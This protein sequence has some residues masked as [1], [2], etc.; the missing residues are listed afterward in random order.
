MT[1][2][3]S[4]AR[5]PRPPRRPPSLAC[6]EVPAML[7]LFGIAVAGCLCF[8]AAT[9]V[10]AQE[11][12]WAQ[13]MFEKQSID[14][15]VVA[16]GADCI[17][18][19]KVTNLYQETIYFRNVSTSCGCS[20]AK[21]S[22]NEIPSGQT[23]YV[24]ISMDTK[25][26]MRKK[27]SSALITLAEPSK[28]LIQE[29][30]I[31]LSVYIRTD[32]VFTPGSANFGAVDQGAPAERKLT[33]N[34]AG[35]NDW[36]IKEVKSPQSYITGAAV[37]TGRPGNGLVNYEVVVNLSA[38]APVGTLRELLTIVTNDDANP[39]VPLPVEARIESEFT[40]QPDLLA[41]GAVPVGQSKTVN[42]VVRGRKPFKI[43]KIEATNPGEAFKVRLPEVERQVHVL[44]FT[45]TAP[46][47]AG[48]ID[49]VFTLLIEGRKEPLTIRAK[50][51]VTSAT[52][53]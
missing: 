7:R 28:G 52:G 43:E 10:S 29:V 44:P 12:N 14:F 26:F 35:R 48:E 4:P 16:R 13:K 22:A 33:L 6:F 20:A 18:R 51:K 19:L 49:E 9:V 30:R 36:E 34:Y 25:R 41:L 27:D 2:C 42:L 45:F 47:E 39:E 46:A 8:T 50:G 17:T 40:F 23:A 38:D 21:P 31:P 3:S 32:V 37:L 1:S 53:G 24:E 15:G 5:I 11:L